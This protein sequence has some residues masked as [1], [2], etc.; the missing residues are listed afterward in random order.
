MVHF[1]RSSTLLESK[2]ES[3]EG[4]VDRKALAK[5]EKR[6]E[7]QRASQAGRTMN[8]LAQ[9]C[10]LLTQRSC[11]FIRWLRLAIDYRSPWKEAVELI[12]P[13][14]DKYLA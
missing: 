4:I 7:S 5:Q 13:L 8:A 11:Q 1:N 6:K 12:R 10:A 9:A 3:D 14:M 2:L